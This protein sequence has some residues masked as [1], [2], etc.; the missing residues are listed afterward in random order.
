M[1]ENSAKGPDAEQGTIAEV[2]PL[3]LDDPLGCYARLAG[4]LDDHTADTFTLNAA[5][6]MPAQLVACLILAYERGIETVF[7]QHGRLT[8]LP[9][10]AHIGLEARFP[11]DEGRI[12]TA[13]AADGEDP[14]VLARRIGLPKSTVERHL[15]TLQKKGA[16]ELTYHSG[17]VH[18]RRTTTGDH[19]T[20]HLRR[21]AR[22][23]ASNGDPD[24]PTAAK[25]ENTISGRP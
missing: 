24:D 11:G 21:A 5:G 1:S 4:I 3:P 8:R 18:A 2:I 23:P 19:L 7:V 16:L 13:L 10:L 20:R 12:L 9:V 17:R 15:R 6:G 22:G 25:T 14:A